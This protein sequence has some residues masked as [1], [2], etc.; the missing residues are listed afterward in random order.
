LVPRR[1]NVEAPRPAVSG[2]PV[3]ALAEDQEPRASGDEPGRRMGASIRG[4]V[5]MEKSGPWFWIGICACLLSAHASAQPASQSTS[6]SGI[7][8]YMSGTQPCDT[9]ILAFQDDTDGDVLRTPEGKFYYSHAATIS[10]WIGGY[11]TA[12]NM[13]VPSGRQ[14]HVDIDGLTRWMKRYCESNPTVTVLSAVNN[15]LLAHGFTKADL[16]G[17]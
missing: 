17:P 9:F 2:W 3:E 11:L 7:A 8:I 16:F 1:V 6:D 4:R 12:V 14:T 13:H 5:V 10:D 15:Y